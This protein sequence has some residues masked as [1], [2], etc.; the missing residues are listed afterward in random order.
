[1]PEARGRYRFIVIEI[2]LTYANQ[3]IVRAI[4]FFSFSVVAVCNP[5]TVLTQA[6]YIITMKRNEMQ[7]G[8]AA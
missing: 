7:R 2:S 3:M 5:Q 6:R 8:T 4:T 1:M